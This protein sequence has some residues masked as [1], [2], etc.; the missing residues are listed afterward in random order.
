MSG[1]VFC[2]DIGGA[3]REGTSLPS[4]SADRS[5]FHGPPGIPPHA[6]TGQLPDVELQPDGHRRE[7]DGGRNETRIG[8]AASG[9]AA[10]LVFV[11]RLATMAFPLAVRRPKNVVL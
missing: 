7:G 4:Y 10:L 2:I 8:W 5:Q 9:N 3:L 6:T 1:F 11:D